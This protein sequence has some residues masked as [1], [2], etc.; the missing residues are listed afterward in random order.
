MRD[1]WITDVMTREVTTCMPNTLLTDVVKQLHTKKFSCLVVINEHHKPVGIIT[2]RDMVTILADMLADV[3]W[4]SLSVENFMT[5][6]PLTI[7]EDHTLFE[8][9][10]LIREEGIRRAPVVNRNNELI[11]IL[12]QTDIINGYYHASVAMAE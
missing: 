6:D 10:E 7:L 1:V 9:V 2:E 4:D 3:S 11:G 12:T 8:A 5:P